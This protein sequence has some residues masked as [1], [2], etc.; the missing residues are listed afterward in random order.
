MYLLEA[1]MLTAAAHNFDHRGRAGR[2]AA[3]RRRAAE[4]DNPE[5]R[6]TT[7]V[8]ANQT[9]LPA[10]RWTRIGTHSHG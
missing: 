1:G 2:S 4:P 7:T 8:V 3:Q 10:P 5:H 6:A 9:S